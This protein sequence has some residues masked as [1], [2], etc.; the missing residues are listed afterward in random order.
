MTIDYYDF[1]VP[2]AITPSPAS[3]VMT[4]R[5]EFAELEREVVRDGVAVWIAAGPSG[6][7]V[8][9]PAGFDERR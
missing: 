7:I 8:A 2:V 6:D 5:E 4:A 1:G 3:Q 9:C